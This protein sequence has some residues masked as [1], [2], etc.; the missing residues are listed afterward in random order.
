MPF[1]HG[2]LRKMVART[3]FSQTSHSLPAESVHGVEYELVLDQ[4]TIPLNEHI[5][6]NIKIS[7]Q[8]AIHCL[9]CQRL[10]NKSFSQGYCYPCFKQLPQCDTCMLKPETCH[11]Q[12]GTCRD[13]QWA[14][15][16]C[17][18]DH[19]VYLA[20]SSG[21][22]VG[23]TRATQMPTRW[24]DQGAIQALPIARVANR[25][26]SGLIEDLLRQQ[27]ADKTNWRQLLKG[28]PAP[29]DLCAKRDELREVFAQELEALDREYP[30]QIEWLHKSGAQQFQYPV[31]QYPTKIV[32][33]NLDKQPDVEGRLMGI[34]GQYLIL[35]TGVINIRKFTAYQVAA[36]I[37]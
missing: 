21:L 5:G 4:Q 15:Q 17:F 8:G 10:T 14:E 37:G 18:N 30:N 20:N 16:V 19:I 35:D 13:N 7:F 29:I 26:L 23:I 28:D 12:Q 6:Q 11:F 34:K 36:T 33:H 2:H 9:H 31:T 24:L 25:R 1:Y 27:V 22:K 32:S 3:S